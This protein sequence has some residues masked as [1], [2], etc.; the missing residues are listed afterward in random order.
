MKTV[1]IADDEE[2]ILS[3][4]QEY[5]AEFGYNVL[6]TTNGDDA[7]KLIKENPKIDLILTDVKMDKISGLELLKLV[8]DFRKDLPVIIISGY[9]TIDNTI[10]A[11]RFGAVDFITK[12]FNLSDLKKVVDRIFSSREKED[13][14][15]KLVHYNKKLAVV[16]Q[17][18]TRELDTEAVSRYLSDLLIQYKVC[19]PGEATQF[20]IVFNEAIV[21]AV[22]HGSLEL[23]SELKKDDISEKDFVRE[24]EKRLK[25]DKY[26]LKK[27]SISLEILEEKFIFSVEDE[28]PGF[29]Y[30]KILQSLND[31]VPNLDAY[32]RGFMF[33]MHMMDNI[34][35]NDKGNKII[36]TK[37]RTKATKS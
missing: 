21:N 5:L 37:F 13:F 36:L 6:T 3:L 8:K 16:Y 32:G 11:L 28:G 2:I 19:N 18:V 23:P 24:K 15:K 22:E 33:M 1:L 20:Y 30:Q 10:E 31:P 34:D 26:G 27:I 14:I 12:P 9:K 17:F 4:V 35:F 7:L 25:D 29:D